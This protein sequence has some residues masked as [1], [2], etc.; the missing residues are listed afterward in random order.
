[1]KKILL[2]ML[3]LFT[4]GVVWA[5]EPV[6]KSDPGEVAIGGID[7]TAY[8]LPAVREKHQEIMGSSKFTVGWKGAKWH[9]VS[10][11]AAAKFAA[12]PARYQPQYNG[13][14]ANALSIGE[15]LIET[16]GATWEFF[17]DRLHLFYAEK[18]RRR[19]LQGDWPAYQKAADAAW[20]EIL[21]E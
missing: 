1:M 13:F 5:G 2:A 9:F 19:W 21:A 20:A 18:G 3:I 16:D 14:C 6:S 7:T 11:Q 10:Q 12:D 17:G 4:S 8:H 15:G